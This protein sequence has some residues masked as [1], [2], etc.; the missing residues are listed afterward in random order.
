MI[1]RKDMPSMKWM[2]AISLSVLT[3]IIS[4]QDSNPKLDSTE[5]VITAAENI[6]FNW[7]DFTW[8]QGN[9]SSHAVFWPQ[10]ILLAVLQLMPITIIHFIIPLITLIPVQPP[11]SE[12]MNLISRT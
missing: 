6:P 9:N 2:I 5:N 11:P 7:G 4:A 8:I 12:V 1:T 10:N 3:A